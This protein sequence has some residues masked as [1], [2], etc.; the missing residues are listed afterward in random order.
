MPLSQNTCDLCY[1]LRISPMGVCSFYPQLCGH[2]PEGI[3]SESECALD[4]QKRRSREHTDSAKCSSIEGFTFPGILLKSRSPGSTPGTSN[5]NRTAEQ[6]PESGDESLLEG[7]WLSWR[8]WG[9][10]EGM[11]LDRKIDGQL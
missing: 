7:S 4:P 5:L 8:W 2:N 10:D 11:P 9:A 1:T 6:Q 3:S